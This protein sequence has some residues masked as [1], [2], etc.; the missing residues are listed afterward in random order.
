MDA[1][2]TTKSIVAVLY[3]QPET[4]LEDYQRLCDL[5]GLAE[6]LDPRATTILKDN[7]SWH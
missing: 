1:F 3:T 7:I 5:A 4:V 2:M 6:A